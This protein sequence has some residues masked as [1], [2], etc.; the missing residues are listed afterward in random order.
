MSAVTPADVFV[1]D[2][3]LVETD[4]IGAGTRIW[5]FAHVMRDAR[6]GVAASNLGVVLEQQGNLDGALDAYR[7]AD[8]RGDANG[9][10]N[11]GVLL[12]QSGDPSGAQAAY[13]R[14]LERGEGQIADNRRGVVLP[15]P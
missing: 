13:R 1:R 4:L 8:Q 12:A 9:A 14:A 15:K 5:A 7:R 3:A 10:F 6:I 11:L 2:R